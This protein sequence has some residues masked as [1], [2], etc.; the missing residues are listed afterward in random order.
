M[1]YRLHRILLFPILLG[2]LGLGCSKAPDLLRLTPAS[3]ESALFQTPLV[4]PQHGETLAGDWAVYYSWG[5]GS[6]SE[7]SWTLS[8]DGTFYSAP[9]N[10]SGKWSVRGR[11]FV[12]AFP[13]GPFVVYTGT[14]DSTGESIAGTMAGNDGSRGCWRAVKVSSPSTDTPA[15]G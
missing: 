2:A 8:A 10:R 6:F 3:S 7:T 5:C 12:L 14:V 9:V 15:A 11:D 1:R 13:Y 4:P